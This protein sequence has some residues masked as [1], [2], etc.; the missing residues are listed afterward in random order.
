MARM[1]IENGKV[2]AIELAGN[3]YSLQQP[4]SLDDPKANKLIS[5]VDFVEKEL[6]FKPKPTDLEAKI[7]EVYF[8][9]YQ[10]N[11]FKLLVENDR[12][13]SLKIQRALNLE[14]GT[15]IA[16]IKQGITRKARSESVPELAAFIKGEWNEKEECNEFWIN[17]TYKAVV[18]AVFG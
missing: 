5:S 8:T 10:K 15:A 3:E 2:L 17:P 1:K 7:R 12:V 6:L 11:L 13:T 18:K 16:G 4:L 9:D 14:N